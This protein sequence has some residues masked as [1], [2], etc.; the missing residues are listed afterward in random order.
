M[1]THDPTPWLMTRDG[2]PAVRARRLLGLR[3][4]DDAETVRAL[5]RRL[6]SEQE[7]DGSLGS[8]PMRTAGA[9]NL[10]DDLRATGSQELIA[11]GALYL[12][13][14]LQSQPGYDRA[15]GVT[16]GSLTAPCDLCGFFGPY[17][18]RSVPEAMVQGAREMNASASTSHS[19]DQSPRCARHGGRA[20]T[21]PDPAPAMHGA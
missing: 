13:S 8:S 14:V 4:D 5:E 12:L 21:G 3:R 1:L 2:L 15:R 11:R 10:L 17:E 20:W 16:P 19:L 6:T 7:A 9:L 18:D